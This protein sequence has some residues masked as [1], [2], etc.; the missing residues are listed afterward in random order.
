MS[1]RKLLLLL[2]IIPVSL[3]AQ[4][5]M[6]NPMVRIAMDT[7]A[8]QIAEN[9]DDYM[10]YY[11]R[12]KDYFKYGEKELALADLNKAIELFP[13]KEEA[14]LSQAYT[15]RALIYQE[16]IILWRLSMTLMKLSDLTLSHVFPYR[17]CRF[18]I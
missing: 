18:I 5:Y 14:D 16:K 13:R 15:L 11:S 4:K 1:I 6:D 8:A 12:A 7:Y 3:S 9:P 2:S 10:P 17:S